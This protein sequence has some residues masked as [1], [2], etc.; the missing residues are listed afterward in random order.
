M[1]Y[2]KKDSGG[3]LDFTGF[4]N[5]TVFEV[6]EFTPASSNSSVTL[7]HSLG[8]KPFY[9]L[10]YTED[11]VSDFSLKDIV[12]GFSGSYGRGIYRYPNS[13]NIGVDGNGLYNTTVTEQVIKVSSGATFEV[14]KKYKYVLLA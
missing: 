5:S 8:V 10:C 12:G 4:L 3:G 7:N 9:F 2:W 1:R 11:M 14:G 13:G 6:G